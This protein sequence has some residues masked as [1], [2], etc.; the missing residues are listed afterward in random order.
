MRTY[1]KII[2]LALSALL[3]AG[4]CGGGDDEPV[5]IGQAGTRP[6]ETTEATTTT[7]EALTTTT[8]APAVVEIPAVPEWGQAWS[9]PTLE[10]GEIRMQ[11]FNEFVLENA[12][13]EVEDVEAVAVYLKPDPADP[14]IQMLEGHAD[15]PEASQITVVINVQDDD[16]VRAFRYEFVVE[17]RSRDFAEVSE[18]E[19]EEAEEGDTSET[20]DELD[21]NEGDAATE[22]DVEVIVGPD[23]I[24]WVLTAELTV[25][26]QPG[27]GHQDFSVEPCV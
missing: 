24:P 8:L 6:T 7:T 25:Q 1:P 19:G 10:L 17:R 26:C 5:E 3:V 2:G 13:D 4:A 14:N 16:S 18:E 23:G 15:G 12:P 9:G 11:E 20:E 27:R 21:T 22:D